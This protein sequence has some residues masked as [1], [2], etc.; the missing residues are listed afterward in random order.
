MSKLMEIIK[1]KRKELDNKNKITKKKKIG[2]L[3]K[4]H[5]S[6]GHVQSLLSTEEKEK[7][8]IITGENVQESIRMAISFYIENKKDDL[9]VINNN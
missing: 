4:I 8:L 1:E 2:R 5:H 9:N 7:L 3:C 6:Y